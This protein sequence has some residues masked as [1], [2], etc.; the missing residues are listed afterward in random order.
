MDDFDRALDYIGEASEPVAEGLRAIHRSL[1]IML[2]AQG[3]TTLSNAWGRNLTLQ[4]M[5]R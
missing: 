4:F 1:G 5:K 3:A 2:W